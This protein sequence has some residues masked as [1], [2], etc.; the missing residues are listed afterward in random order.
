MEI[1]KKKIFHIIHS[2]VSGEPFFRYSNSAYRML[3][4]PAKPAFSFMGKKS[5]SGKRKISKRFFVRKQRTCNSP[6]RSKPSVIQYLDN[7]DESEIEIYI[8]PDRPCKGVSTYATIGLSDFSIGLKTAGNKELRV[9]FIGACASNYEM[10]AN[11]ISTCAFNIINSK[12]SCKPGTVYSNVVKMYYQDLDMKHIFFTDPFLWDNLHSLEMDDLY[13]AWLMAVPISDNE[14]N[15]LKQ[16][17][18]EALEKLFE[19]K[20]IDAYD[21]NRRSIL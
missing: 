20:D 11:I 3:S 17:G 2:A 16:N 14:F 21:L 12:F 4:A 10:F 8:G 9:E 13:V 18:S 7:N 1:D 19:E 6:Q 15:F 5:D